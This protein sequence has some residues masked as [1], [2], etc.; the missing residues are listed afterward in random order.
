MA[1]RGEAV[2]QELVPGRVPAAAGGGR[3]V[4]HPDE[5]P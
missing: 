3:V 4:Q 1:S 5:N 2:R